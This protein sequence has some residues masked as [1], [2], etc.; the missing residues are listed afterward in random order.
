ML[1]VLCERTPAPRTRAHGRVH[2]R[3]GGSAANAAVW[4][5]ATGAESTAVGRVG[6]DP[7]A[8]LVD[9]AL[10]RRG[11]TPLLARDPHVRTGVVLLVGDGG[12]DGIVADRGASSRLAPDDLP[13]RLEADAVLV[14]GYT[15]LHPD[16]RA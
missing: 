12:R 7:A 15:L 4:A 6:D 8:A 16:T 5:A 3:P 2:L 10:R 14:S 1:D 11:V 13:E 9:Q